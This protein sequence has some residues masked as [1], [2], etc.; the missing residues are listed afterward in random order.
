MRQ[1]VEGTFK[2]ES[3]LSRLSTDRI[4]KVVALGSAETAK[5]TNT[6]HLVS[7]SRKR[8]GDEEGR[9]RFISVRGEGNQPPRGRKDFK[10]NDIA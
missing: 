9:A 7:L 5:L 3:C 10:T 1:C 8:M 6:Q 4:R 2:V